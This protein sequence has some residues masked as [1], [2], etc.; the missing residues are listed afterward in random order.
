M[1]LKPMRLLKPGATL[2]EEIFQQLLDHPE[3]VWVGKVD[4]ENN[5]ASLK[6]ADGKIFLYI[7]ELLDELQSIDAESEEVALVLPREYPLI[8]M[9][10]RHISM[11]AN[12]SRRV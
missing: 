9:A 4:P 12:A 6:R 7:P 11:N 3:G 5:L 10:G 2:G 1:T 8:L